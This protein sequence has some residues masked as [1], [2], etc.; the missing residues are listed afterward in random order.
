M[1]SIALQH[2]RSL[3]REETVLVLIALL[4]GITLASSFIGWSSHRTVTAVYEQ[5]VIALR[6][7]GKIIPPNPFGTQPGLSILKNMVIYIPLVGA[8]LA[9]IVGQT[10]VTSDYLAG[11]M[12]LIFSRPVSRRQYMG[13]KILGIAYVLSGIIAVCLGTSLISMLVVNGHAPSTFELF[14]LSLF[15][16]L[17]FLYLMLFALIGFSA[18]LMTRSQS[19]SLLGSIGVWIVISFVVPQFAS[20]VRPIAS[21]NPVSASVGTS[22]T[23]FFRATQ[24]IKP[25]SLSERF[26]DLGIQLLDAIPKSE[27]T[28]VAP[29]VVPLCVALF[30]VFAFGWRRMKNVHIYEDSIND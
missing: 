11:V 24:I 2:V 13:G 23:A 27:Q 30:G 3:V 15:Y 5:T 26:K 10:S 8:L 20:G 9:I 7:G 1:N 18:A 14:K 25:F 22:Q 4:F 28:S 16:G 12:K 19:L 6:A 29:Q 21:L 17:S